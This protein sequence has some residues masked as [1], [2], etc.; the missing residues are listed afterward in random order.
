MDA[1]SEC[2]CFTRGSESHESQSL[3][4]PSQ[5]RKRGALFRTTETHLAHETARFVTQILWSKVV[6]CTSA[7]GCPWSTCH[8]TDPPLRRSWGSTRARPTRSSRAVLETVVP[9]ACVDSDAFRRAELLPSLQL[10]AVA[11]VVLSNVRG[12]ESNQ[13][14]VFWTP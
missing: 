4:L 3:Q 5:G 7:C 6:K 11:L 14:D 1:P 10:D 2:S 9:A 8:R 12:S 13:L